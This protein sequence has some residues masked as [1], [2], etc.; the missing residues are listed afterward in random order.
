[1]AKRKLGKQRAAA[2]LCNQ[3]PANARAPT[4]ALPAAGCPTET[5]PLRANN[6]GRWLPMDKQNACY[7]RAR[8]RTRAR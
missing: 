2:R 7:T 1:M 5:R 4:P 8:D 6:W 3:L